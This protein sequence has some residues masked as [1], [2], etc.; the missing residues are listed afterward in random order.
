MNENNTQKKML[1]IHIYALVLYEMVPQTGE[2]IRTLHF[3]NHSSE[4]NI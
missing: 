1:I 2:I 4:R 3:T